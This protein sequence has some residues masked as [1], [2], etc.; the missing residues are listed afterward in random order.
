MSIAIHFNLVELF[1]SNYNQ[2][3]SYPNEGLVQ[4]LLLRIAAGL[5]WSVFLFI[6]TAASSFKELVAHNQ[7]RFVIDRQP[8]WSELLIVTD[9]FATPSMMQQK[10]GHFLG[11]FIL[12]F[13]LTAGS[14]SRAGLYLSIGFAVAT[15]IA[16]LYFGRDGR[17]IDMFIDS[18]GIIA[19]FVF[20]RFLS[21]AK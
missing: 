5:V 17:I 18:A 7:V 14:R 19:A 13:I 6:G 15:E 16:Q 8:D 2:K 12:C 10:L 11:F 20:T 9:I 1:A 3:Q 4:L 21:A